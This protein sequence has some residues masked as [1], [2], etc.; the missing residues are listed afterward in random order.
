MKLFKFLMVSATA[1]VI[2]SC[3][4]GD[5]FGRLQ[6]FNPLPVSTKLSASENSE[7]PLNQEAASERDATQYFDGTGA[8]YSTDQRSNM[9]R[10]SKSGDVNL[11]FTNVEI[12][13]VVD[14]VL[15]DV[16]GVAYTIDP[17]IRGTISLE[18][19]DGV[20]KMTAFYALESALKLRG[21]AIVPV[22]QSYK[23]VPLSA[24]P[25]SVTGFSGTR[26]ASV[27]L[28]GFA[29]QIVPIKYTS[30]AEM[31]RVLE[32]FAPNGGILKVDEARK[33]MI[34]AG[35]SEELASMRQVI[36]T[37]DLDW[38]QGMSFALYDLQFV[39]SEV[40]AKELLQIFG[41]ADSPMAGTVRLIPLKTLNK[42]LGISAQTSYLRQVN[43]W[44]SRLDVGDSMPGRR[45]Y[46][47]H[48]QNGKAADIAASLSA[49]LGNQMVSTQLGQ[50]N[51]SGEQ[52]KTG[53]NIPMQPNV[54]GME[55]AGIRIVPSDE[56][57]LILIMASPAEYSVISNAL[58][59]MDMAPRMVL[60]E[61]ALAE[62][63][64]TNELRH[65]VSWIFENGTNNIALSTSGS[66]PAQQF[67]GFSYSYTGISNVRA[68]LNAL[69]GI[70]D[71]NVVSYP[72][73]MALNNHPATIQIGDEVPV[74]IQ[75]SVSSSN[76]DAPIV[77]SVEY[78]DTGVILT[79]TP[80][81]NEGGLVIL[82]ISQEIS[83]V[84]ETTSSGIDAPT[85]Q[86]RKIESTVAVQ[87]GQTIALGGLIR[88]VQSVT[89]SGVPVLQRI[90][91]LGS[92]F[93]NTSKVDRRTELIV[94]IT[95]RV[96]RDVSET[97]AVMEY[98]AET[99]KNVMP[100]KGDDI[101]N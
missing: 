78:R 85:I 44:V 1:L 54:G 12:S 75:S 67:P 49:I 87:D 57:N 19:T 83:D 8:L 65:G 77:N 14:A 39:D 58:K 63:T 43:D 70:T 53:S 7:I 56:N 55:T 60:I 97:K 30:P 82:E 3:S 89:K 24:A 94:L 61:A 79:V 80:R 22:G 62:V 42:L 72:K 26:P 69:E 15:K 45:I 11:S 73:L 84:V 4:N 29:V 34:L 68:V 50:S 2:T 38:M 18:T 17:N 16:M 40:I 5:K 88:Q 71:V 31:R 36:T 6:P 96:I 52:T 27:N 48:V 64:L 81:I 23:V 74:P 10:K 46:V 32:P 37:F 95:P 86:Q 9:V 21:V 66:G 51:V 92:A 28:P 35:T 25:K 13:I 101:E 100:A 98:L 90:P 20:D 41:D 33:L 91:L 99:F 47:Y 93:R 59:Q 76:P